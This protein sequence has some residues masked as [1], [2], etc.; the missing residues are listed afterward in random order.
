MAEEVI[1][2][3]SGFQDGTFEFIVAS[4]AKLYLGEEP[5]ALAVNF[6]IEKFSQIRNYPKTYTDEKILEDMTKHISTIAM[7]VVDLESKVGSEGEI[8]NSDNGISVQFENAF[9]SSSVF[10]SVIP[11]VDTF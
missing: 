10:A 7:A 5:T 6:S 8:S 4:K 9:I 11:F 2:T 3:V 1:T